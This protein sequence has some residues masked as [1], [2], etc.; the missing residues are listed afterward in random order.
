MV[1]VRGGAAEEWRGEVSEGAHAIVDRKKYSGLPV[2]DTTVSL[3]HDI[4]FR[5]RFWRR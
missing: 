4:V 2:N 3:T 1:K 5:R